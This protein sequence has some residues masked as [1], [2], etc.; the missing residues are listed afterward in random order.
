MPVAPRVNPYISTLQI[1]HCRGLH[2]SRGDPT[3][4][5]PSQLRFFRLNSVL[6]VAFKFDIFNAE[7]VDIL[8]TLFNKFVVL[9]FE[10][11]VVCSFIKFNSVVDVEFIFD[12]LLLLLII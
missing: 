3:C 8:F 9:K 5:C 11:C 7:Y 6:D 2:C 1:V 12:I 10:I 4:F